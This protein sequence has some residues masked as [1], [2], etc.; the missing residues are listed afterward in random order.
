MTKKSLPIDAPDDHIRPDLDKLLAK[1]LP[2]LRLQDWDVTAD[3]HRRHE[4]D[5]AVG[6]CDIHLK[7]NLAHIRI[8]EPSD[9]DPSNRGNNGVEETLVHELR[10]LSFCH[11]RP[12]RDSYQYKLWERCIDMDSLILVGLTRK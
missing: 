6:D 4:M 3:Y 2:I 5:G 9:L 11:F 10:H 1:W 7:R 8:M 12:D